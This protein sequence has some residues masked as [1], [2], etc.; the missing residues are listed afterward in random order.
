MKLPIKEELVLPEGVTAAISADSLLTV[1]GP[2]GEMSRSFLSPKIQITSKGGKL[3]LFCPRGTKRE[4]NTIN[5]IV[6][7]IK[8][9]FRGV[10][11]PFIFKL[12]I[13]SGHF[14]MTVA[15]KDGFFEVKN[16]LGEKNPRRRRVKQG[17]N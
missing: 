14:P 2:K 17:A 4:K 8:N 15:Q 3:E 6:A 11:D 7:H 1:K 5:T 12:K 10:R 13:C 16:F 9:M